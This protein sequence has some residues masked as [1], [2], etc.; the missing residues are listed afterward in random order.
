MQPIGLVSE[1]HLG[2]LT[3]PNYNPEDMCQIGSDVVKIVNDLVELCA[4][5]SCVEG[6]NIPFNYY[7]FPN[8]STPMHLDDY[9]LS[10]TSFHVAGATKVW[11]SIAPKDKLRFQKLVELSLPSQF[12]KT[13]EVCDRKLSG[14]KLMF[15][16]ELLEKWQVK[17]L[18]V[19][20]NPGDLLLLNGNTYHQVHNP[21]FNIV[22]GINHNDDRSAASEII[23][24]GHGAPRVVSH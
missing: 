18:V 23:C 1:Y 4:D 10:T 11:I 2:E 19:L 7:G 21:G 17:Y 3:G 12:K 6:L 24:E 20:Q 9:G 13:A 22:R 8:S 5:T 15:T 14:A 16:P